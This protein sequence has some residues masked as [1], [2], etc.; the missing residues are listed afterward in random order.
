MPDVVA[1]QRAGATAG[2]QQHR[3][4]FATAFRAKRNWR[5]ERCLGRKEKSGRR[6]WSAA[7]RP[8]KPAS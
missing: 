4:A 8:A 7:R 2:G 5:P 3:H 6:S 1:L